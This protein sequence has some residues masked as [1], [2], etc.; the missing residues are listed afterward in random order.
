MFPHSAT[1]TA[2]NAPKGSLHRRGAVARI[3]FSFRCSFESGEG[4]VMV[5]RV[6][7]LSPGSRNNTRRAASLLTCQGNTK[8]TIVTG[9]LCGQISSGIHKFLPF[10]SPVCDL[11]QHTADCLL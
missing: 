10:G 4:H 1:A 3:R 11:L 5:R 6:E 2:Q 7:N 8:F 9:S